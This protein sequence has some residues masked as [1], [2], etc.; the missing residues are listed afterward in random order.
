MIGQNLDG[1]PN[2]PYFAVPSAAC[3]ALFALRIRSIGSM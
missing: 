3:P 1:Q 2:S